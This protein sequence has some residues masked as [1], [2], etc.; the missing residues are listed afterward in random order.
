MPQGAS[1]LAKSGPK[2]QTKQS[3][4]PK[5]GQRTIAPKRHS[6]VKAAAQ[7]KQLSA[8]LTRSIEKQT[9]T[10]ASSGKLTIMKNAATGDS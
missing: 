9:A 2:R 6:L 5:K 4:N 10:A 8:K 1:K 3:I 7:K